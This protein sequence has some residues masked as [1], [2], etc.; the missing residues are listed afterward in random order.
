MSVY[1]LCTTADR[2]KPVTHTRVRLGKSPLSVTFDPRTAGLLVS[3]QMWLERA[4]RETYAYRHIP[5]VKGHN[6]IHVHTA[7]YT[8]S[9]HSDLICRND[10]VTVRTV[11]QMSTPPIPCI[12]QDIWL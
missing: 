3:V 12:Y 9:S 1:V 8:D 7:A 5:E 11:N 6:G 4:G 2:S 10:D